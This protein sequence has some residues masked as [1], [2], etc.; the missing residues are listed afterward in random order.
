MERTE[1]V[2]KLKII[3]NDKRSCYTKSTE[4]KGEGFVPYNVPYMQKKS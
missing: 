2:R 4:K 3:I 1:F